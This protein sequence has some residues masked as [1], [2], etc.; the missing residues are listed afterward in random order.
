M[1]GAVLY[2]VV[3][4][5]YTV[6]LAATSPEVTRRDSGRWMVPWGRWGEVRRDLRDA[7]AEEGNGHARGFWDWCVEQ[8]GAFM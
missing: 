3:F 4:G 7:V 2:P 1:S 8:V 6:L 5:A